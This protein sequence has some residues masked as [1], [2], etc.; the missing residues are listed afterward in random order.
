MGTILLFSVM[1]VTITSALP[2]AEL[3]FFCLG[4]SH[5]AYLSL[6]TPGLLPL[7]PK[8]HVSTLQVS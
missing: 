1:S 3:L 5:Y 4:L 8:A 2:Q 7:K 6:P